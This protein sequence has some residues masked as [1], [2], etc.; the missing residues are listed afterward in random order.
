MCID[1]AARMFSFFIEYPKGNIRDEESVY[2]TVFKLLGYDVNDKIIA[3]TTSYFH[4]NEKFRVFGDVKP[5][6]RE[7]KRKL[8]KTAIVTSTPRFVFERILKENSILKYIDAIITP[9]EAG[10]T[11][12]DPRIYLTGVEHLSVP[13]EDCVYVTDN[14]Y[15]DGPP[16]K[17]LGIKYILVDRKSRARKPKPSCTI[18]ST[19]KQIPALLNRM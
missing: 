13:V 16:L 12:P 1:V 11:K 3:I 5:C 7:L 9:F 15:L 18:I 19:L 8:C 4:V 10:V 14:I 17:E 6:L 2:K